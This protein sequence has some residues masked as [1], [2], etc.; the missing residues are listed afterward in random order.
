MMQNMTLSVIP[1]SSTNSVYVKSS[2]IHHMGPRGSIVSPPSIRGS[3]AGGIVG[4][5]VPAQTGGILSSNRM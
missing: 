5:P 1:K 2:V 4:A 3:G